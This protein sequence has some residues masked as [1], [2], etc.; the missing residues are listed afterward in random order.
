MESDLFNGALPFPINFTTLSI[1]LV[2]LIAVIAFLRGVI[3]MFVG[4]GGN[5]DRFRDLRVDD[6]QTP[7]EELQRVYDK[8]IKLFPRPK[9][10]E[11]KK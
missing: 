4:L 5:N 2:I 6:H 9:K 10:Y 3:G 7:I 1:A 11:L 8:H